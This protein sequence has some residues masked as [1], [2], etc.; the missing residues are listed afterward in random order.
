MIL[1]ITLLTLLVQISI[2]RILHILS[3]RYKFSFLAIAEYDSVDQ[4][5]DIAL[6]DPIQLWKNAYANSY[7]GPGTWDHFLFTTKP[8]PTSRISKAPYVSV[9]LQAE[10]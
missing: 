7:Q 3:S 10:K 4:D 6:I 5:E 2:S 9:R 8:A 1:K